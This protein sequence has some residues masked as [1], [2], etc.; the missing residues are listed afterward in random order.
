MAAHKEHQSRDHQNARPVKNKPG[1]DTTSA[2]AV[3]TSNLN[4]SKIVR[5]YRCPTGSTLNVRRRY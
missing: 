4:L 1:E 5:R 2:T 3:P